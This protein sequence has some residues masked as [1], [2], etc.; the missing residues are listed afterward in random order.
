VLHSASPH[1]AATVSGEVGRCLERFT[2]PDEAEVGP[3]LE[4]IGDADVVL[5]GEASHG[6]YE[7]YRLRDRI[8]RA[9]VTQKGFT[10]VAVEADWPDAA[11]I[12]AHVRGRPSPTPHL[13]PFSRFP[14]WMWRNEPMQYFVRWLRHH[15]AEIRDPAQQVRFHG[16]DLYSLFESR[17][18]VLTYLDR[19]DPGAA[20]AAR[21]R[22][23]CLTPW[24]DDP[25]AYGH[26]ATSGR[27]TSCE[28]GV[29][30]TLVDLLQQ[31]AAY[32]E[33]DGD[34]LLDAIQN[35]AVVVDAERYYR[36]MYEGSAASWNLRDQ[37][38]YETLRHVR[39]ARGPDAKVVVWEHNSHIGDASATEM[40]ARG[41]HNVGQLCREEHGDRAFLVGFGTH[42]GTVAAASQW[43]GRMERKPVR[44][45]HPDSYERIF[46]D[47]GVPAGFLHLREPD[48]PEVREA[49]AEPRLERAI[50]VIYRPETERQSHY[51]HA[52]L[53]DQ[54]DEYIWIDET[55]AVRPVAAHQLAGALDT[56]PFGL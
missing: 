7:F 9:L 16:L 15:N 26:A 8:T 2:S 31:R 14:T 13:E 30:R 6:T 54:F 45:S 36:V 22:Y 46:H 29:V 28:P 35:A 53:P 47:T 3:L 41:E 43:G 27:M 34:D 50:G 17:D 1:H 55:Q 42:T 39:A 52:V 49:L 51:F 25:A 20:E 10:V 32:A 44:P 5:L 48:R 4:R 40:G 56:Y 33:A 23:G 38:M 24:E 19:V 12:D 21:H 18:A 37:H 11:R